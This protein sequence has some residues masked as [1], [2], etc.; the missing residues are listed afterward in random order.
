MKIQPLQ[1]QKTYNG[2]IHQEATITHIYKSNNKQEGETDYT[3]RT[4]MTGTILSNETLNVRPGYRGTIQIEGTDDTRHFFN[5]C[6][7]HPCNLA[8]GTK[9]LFATSSTAS[10]L[11]TKIINI[12]PIH[13]EMNRKIIQHGLHEQHKLSLTNNSQAQITLFIGGER[14]LQ[15]P[16]FPVTSQ[17]LIQTDTDNNIL[18]QIL[19][20]TLEFYNNPPSE[21]TEEEK[22]AYANHSRTLRN[23]HKGSNF[24]ILIN[25]YDFHSISPIQWYKI[26][27]DFKKTTKTYQVRRIFI[28]KKADIETNIRNI[29]LMLSLAT[30]QRTPGGE[31]IGR[32]LYPEKPLSLTSYAFGEIPT[33]R[34][35]SQYNLALIRLD[36]KEQPTTFDY[37]PLYIEHHGDE[38]DSTLEQELILKPEH[39]N[40][41]LLTISFE[42][43]TPPD[44]LR[45][46]RRA[47]QGKAQLLPNYEGIKFNRLD[48]HAA[49][50][51][52]CKELDET[53]DS[54]ATLKIDPT[55]PSHSTHN[56]FIA[57]PQAEYIYPT[58]PELHMTILFENQAN[59]PLL[60][61]LTQ[62]SPERLYMRPKTSDHTE[63]RILFKS[64]KQK[65]HLLGNIH[66][67]WEGSGKKRRNRK[68]SHTKT[69]YGNIIGYFHKSNEITWKEAIRQPRN[70]ETNHTHKYTPN[71]QPC[72]GPGPIFLKGVSTAL[73][74]TTLIEIAKGYGADLESGL[75]EW[76][77]L[78]GGISLL[79]FQA[80][81]QRISMEKPQ[82]TY[83]SGVIE[84]TP[85]PNLNYYEQH[86]TPLTTQ[87]QSNPS[88]SQ[89]NVTATIPIY[90][91]QAIAEAT[92]A[93]HEK[94]F[95]A[96]PLSNSSTTQTQ[97]QEAQK[98]K[99][100][101]T[102]SPN[103]N[104]P[105]PPKQNR[106]I[107]LYVNDS[108]DDDENEPPPRKKPTR[109]K[110]TKE[111]K[112]PGTHT[113]HSHDPDKDH[114]NQTFE[115][116]WRTDSDDLRTE[117][118]DE[119][120][121]EADPVPTPKTKAA[122]GLAASEL[123][124]MKKSATT[125]EKEKEARRRQ[126]A[127]KEQDDE[128][129]VIENTHRT[130]KQQRKKDKEK[131]AGKRLRADA[132]KATRTAKERQEG[133]ENRAARVRTRNRSTQRQQKRSSSTGTLRR[134]TESKKR[135]KPTNL[136]SGTEDSEDMEMAAS[137]P[138]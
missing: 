93:T 137:P 57:F 102:I 62:G 107:S 7:K 67:A 15:T 12:I 118:G 38:T 22:R 79:K 47:L 45:H 81:S 52:T 40:P 53:I 11:K 66:K 135:T 133:T 70:H 58:K 28:L 100:K 41:N 131:E 18:E 116:D 48:A 95:I 64:E 73:T 106:Y 13:E 123:A 32:V 50:N 31:M 30:E 19:D 8:I 125:R 98:P 124:Q 14:G 92:R 51:I 80:F 115:E 33:H 10:G 61:A 44:A 26:I 104:K 6:L 96:P 49:E 120:A 46:L 97:T 127:E 2:V 88:Q 108:D 126:A 54:L 77:H 121:D 83:L 65:E 112:R 74:K 1:T 85:P 3:E 103:Q 21:A 90:L 82:R 55:N 99:N 39:L 130:T 110:K 63:M 71:F 128:I 29:P 119:E 136:A 17:N 23:A 132:E 24:N 91:T 105:Q 114:S 36:L 68:S 101:S 75:P 34:T 113:A 69:S 89:G 37:A 76:L 109:K 111:D 60:E 5:S 16:T 59:P 35:D 84:T 43:E 9:V 138:Y 117:V 87:T 134:P 122:G 72:E 86:T 27:Q 20:H 129:L 42:E 4:F 56:P 78:S 25:P 94:Q